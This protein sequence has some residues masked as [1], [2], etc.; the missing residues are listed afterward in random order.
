M[1]QNRNLIPSKEVEASL[2]RTRQPLAESLYDFNLY[3]TFVFRLFCRNASIGLSDCYGGLIFP[4]SPHSRETFYLLQE[5]LRCVSSF[6]L[7]LS[8]FTSS[9]DIFANVYT[10]C[11]KNAYVVFCNWG[12]SP[13]SFLR[14]NSSF[15]ICRNA[16]CVFS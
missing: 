12:G 3:S 11:K 4:Q 10:Y 16:Q 13:L 8:N 9:Y 1:I 14:T 2:I 6:N 15:L 7:P 5:H